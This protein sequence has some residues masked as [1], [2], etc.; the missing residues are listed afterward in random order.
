METEVFKTSAAEW[1]LRSASATSLSVKPRS[2]NGGRPGIRRHN[3]PGATN[4]PVHIEVVAYKAPRR[5]IIM[6]LLRSDEIETMVEY[7]VQPSKGQIIAARAAAVRSSGDQFLARLKRGRAE[8]YHL[9]WDVAAASEFLSDY[10]KLPDDVK[11][12]VMHNVATLVHAK[13][14]NMFGEYENDWVVLEIGRK[15]H[16]VYHFSHY[17]HTLFLLFAREK[18]GAYDGPLRVKLPRLDKWSDDPDFEFAL[19]GHESALAESYERDI[20]GE[21]LRR[22]LHGGGHS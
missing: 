7:T 18:Y 6:G 19:V 8:C 5:N 4:F 22:Q 20:F 15:F 3:L 13:W 14:P 17:D 9:P 1:K 2:G 21:S 11:E 16:T 10:D 12:C